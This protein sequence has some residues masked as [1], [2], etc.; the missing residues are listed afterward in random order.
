MTVNKYPTRPANDSMSLH[1]LL[2]LSISQWKWFVL[3]LGC[4]LSIA[5]LYILMTPPVYT[6]SA[7]I[8]I[9]EDAKGN[10]SFSAE[11]N[12][13]ADMGLFNTSANVNNELTSIQS[14]ALLLEVVK[15]LHLYMDYKVDGLFH[16]QTLY[17]HTLPLT[18]SVIG[19]A[20][21]DF[22]SFTLQLDP[23]GTI[24]LS[25]LSLNGETIRNETPWQG[26]LNDSI[27]T[28]IGKIV[29]AATPY[30]RPEPLT[31]SV[32]RSGIISCV[33]ACLLQLSAA[34]SNEKTTIINLSYQDVSIQRAEEFL[35][36]LISVYNENWVKDK[37]LIAVSTSHFINER[38]SVIEQELGSV[39]SDISSYKSENLIP[40][41]QAAS[42]M[43]MVQANEASTQILRLNNELYMARYIRNFVANA[44]NQHQLLPANS[45]INSPIVERQIAEY[46]DKLL[47][48]NNLV[49]NSS[50]HNPLAIDMDTA[51][52]SM[53][54]A[55]ISSIDNQ[56]NALNTQIRGLRTS[57]QQ[58]TAR[59]ASNP[60]QAKY[61][62]SVERQQ[63]VKEALYLFL[64]QKREE[65]E[66]SQ[67]FTAYNTRIITPPTGK[68]TP[69]APVKRNILLAGFLIGL[70]IPVGLIIL[71]ENMNTKVRGRKDLEKLTIPFV[72]EI[73]LY[74][75]GKG[76]G[77]SRRKKGAGSGEYTI[78]VKEKS[79]NIINEAF[80]VIRTNIEF[81][82]EQDAGNKVIMVSSVNPGS[83]K[84]FV[85]MNLAAGFSIK[86]KKTIVL[87]L[88][89]RKASLS[90]YVDTPGQGISDYLSNRIER[91]EDTLVKDENYPLLDILPVGTVPPNP[92]ELLFKPKLEHLLTTLR[93]LYDVVIIDCPPIDIVADSSIIAQWA[94]MT[95]FIVRA[96]VMEREM[97]PLVESYYK[98]KKLRN[99]ALLLNGTV[100]YGHSGYHRYGYH[101]GYGYGNYTK[102]E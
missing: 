30:Y 79:R 97:L 18:A 17:G 102:D 55:I 36:T 96:G 37:N 78:L 1:D 59:I 11:L 71:R 57:E 48:R 90:N 70:L 74:G 61:L 31:L 7:S 88:D 85:T 89:L 50:E 44:G 94:D 3:S 76:R 68:L 32:S 21:N 98:E 77:K 54:K 53:R 56:I 33:E 4:T 75:K 87:D 35:N 83:G 86:E 95:L 45:G 92:A 84:T 5:V 60:T 34:L 46:N 23:N 82:L 14:P 26:M 29:V 99:M 91:W 24:Q 101:Y 25:D 19:L 39:D 27:A 2:A 62:L 80:R 47:Q 81:M 40:D 69:T 12:S 38:L 8:L 28:P 6:R 43:Y 16:Q 65:N 100:A 41:V 51:L 66:L 52:G 10:S 63:K 72:G 73:P 64:L 49:A 13:F 20:D 67:A 58:N 9:K 22:C 42:N 15:R 93:D